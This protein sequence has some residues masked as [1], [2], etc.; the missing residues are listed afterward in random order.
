MSNGYL[1]AQGSGVWRDLY[2]FVYHNLRKRGLS[3]FDAE[4][5]AQDVL[6]TACLHLDTVEPGRRHAWLL[7]VTRNKLVD[8]ARRVGRVHS[9]AE[10]PDARDP[11]LGPD[12]IAFRSMDRQILLEA[13]ACLPER[14]RL[15]VEI[16]YLEE[17]T[18]A[19]SALALGMSVGATKVA[20]HR[21][22]ER[23]R[24]ALESTG[25]TLDLEG[26][27]DVDGAT[28]PYYAARK[29]AAMSGI[30]ERAVNAL[31]PYVG[32]AVADLCVRGTAVSIDKTF[33]TLTIE[34]SEAL[35]QRARQVL[36]SL[37]PPD[38]IERV[39]AGIRGGAL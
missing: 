10:V 31:S 11:A 14:D 9:V 29:G 2:G 36:A 33:D 19:E 30:A 5:L 4:D 23:L 38:A 28:R 15:L 21:A 7:T 25:T 8:R 22:R 24:V 17:C 20:L 6:E 13:V 1:M 27:S 39:V 3:H 26:A 12:E 34:D 37:L 35:E 16:R 32:A 18:I